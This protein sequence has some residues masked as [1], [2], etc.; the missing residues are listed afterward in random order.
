MVNQESG[1]EEIMKKQFCTKCGAS[2]RE[3]ARFCVKCGA[4]VKTFDEGE[5]DISP[6]ANLKVKNE[7]PPIIDKLENT[8]IDKNVTQNFNIGNED[9]ED[10]L[11][12]MW[13]TLPEEHL[14]Q[15]KTQEQSVDAGQQQNKH[16]TSEKAKEKVKL[17]DDSLTKQSVQTEQSNCFCPYC[18]KLING[19]E[20]ICPHCGASLLSVETKSENHHKHN[21]T[22]DLGHYTHKEALIFGV[23][24]IVFV[25]LGFVGGLQN[26]NKA[27]NTFRPVNTTQ[28]VQKAPEIINVTAEKLMG[29]YNTDRTAADKKYVGKKIAVSGVVVRIIN[30]NNTDKNK[31]ITLYQWSYGDNRY[32]VNIGVPADEKDIVDNIH[33]GDHIVATGNFSGSWKQQDSSYFVLGMNTT[34][35]KKQ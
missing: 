17:L 4:P 3:D 11:S 20:D 35:I 21:S 30:F 8:V 32:E 33:A 31:C 23:I 7:T 12:I 13:G 14:V 29:D 27:I 9:N 16:T 26:Y 24:L 5:I 2:L 19:D 18:F 6:A 22:D 28:N 34:D 1:G 15:V 25:A 10:P